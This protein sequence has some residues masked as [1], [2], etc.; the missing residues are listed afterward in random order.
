M[1]KRGITLTIAILVASVLAFTSCDIISEKG[2]LEESLNV[3][4]NVSLI[5]GAENA[6]VRVNR[7]TTSNFIVDIQNVKWNNLISNGERDAY[8][9]AWKDPISSN[10]DIYEGVG[11][12]STAGDKQF[13]GVNRLFS[14]KNALLKADPD[15]TWREIQVA[16]WELIPFQ[17]FDMNMPVNQLPSE[18]RLNG[19]ANFNKERVQ[20]ILD[21]VNDDSFATMSSDTP[22]CVI[23]TDGDTQTLITE[24]DET[25]FAYGGLMGPNSTE[26]AGQVDGDYN[27]IDGYAHC[28]PIDGQITENQWG[29]SN[30]K[31]SEGSSYTW[32]LYAGAGQC[33]LNKGQYAGDLE[34]DYDNGLLT[35][36]YIATPGSSFKETHLYVGANKMPDMDSNTGYGNYPYHDGN[37]T[38]V[39][40]TEVVYE[41]EISGDIYI[42]AHSVVYGSFA[43]E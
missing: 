34:V 36:K 5:E 32:P 17:E 18:V 9:I 37:A 21:A 12:Y 1:I 16:I 30:G 8:C 31:I 40:D 41:I 43:E 24:C 23:G 22:T 6:N 4:P 39:T 38:S 42:V 20:F 7:G 11:V 14:I 29:W 33:I 25:A 10:N 13:A 15:I 27:S 28:F 26:Q 19:Q 2:S 35:V 3:V